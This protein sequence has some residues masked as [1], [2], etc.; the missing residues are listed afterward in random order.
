MDRNQIDTIHELAFVNTNM[1]AL[2]MSSN[3]LK[4]SSMDDTPFAHLIELRSLNVR[5]NSLDAFLTVWNTNCLHLERLDLSHNAIGVLNLGIVFD[6]WKRP[7]V[8][9]LSH[10]QL[11]TIITAYDIAS[12]PNSTWILN[13]NPLRC[14]C[15]VQPLVE[16]IRRPNEKIGLVVD[17][18]RC[19]APERLAGQSPITVDLAQLTCPLDSPGGAAKLCPAGCQCDVRVSDRTAIFNCT[20]A[21]LT[22]VP[23]LPAKDKLAGIRSYHLHIEHNR[24]GRLPARNTTGY[25]DVNYLFAGNNSIGSVAADELPDAMDLL[26]LT[27]N[28][29]WWLGGDALAHLGRMERLQNISLHANPWLCNCA[30]VEL[31]R[32]VR[33]NAHRIRASGRIMCANAP[34]TRLLDASDLCFW[35][36]LAV[37]VGGAAIAAVIV[38][39]AGLVLFHAYKLDALIWW[40]E[41][42]ARMC[43][44]LARRGR[45]D[46]K[47]FD[48]FVA[49]A[50]K[51][52]DFV[53]DNLVKEL[54]GGRPALKLRS[55]DRD[56]LAGECMQEKVSFYFGFRFFFRF[57]FSVF[58]ISANNLPA[59][60]RTFFRSQVTEFVEKSRKTIVVLTPNLVDSITKRR[61]AEHA[62][63]ETIVDSWTL[64]AF[65]FAHERGLQD[66]SSRIIIVICGNI[67]PIDDL[68]AELKAYL[69]THIYLRWDESRF[70]KKL[71]YAITHAN[72]PQKVRRDYV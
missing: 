48:A 14:D 52:A 29:I 27:A 11:S 44:S 65:L 59:V 64:R 15:L 22:A 72:Y 18:L 17:D 40:D 58:L 54:E 23:P 2:D 71:R 24:I 36:E 3:R 7:V 70:F 60:L 35:N 61:E 51:D 41:S 45:P 12:Q 1:R 26:D 62:T 6:Y 21:N 57:L 30:A 69:D 53:H 16:S 39:L 13:D 42:R 4:F 38:L 55:L 10:N 50:S 33:A 68:A 46:G 67:G 9:D 56:M 5:N 34:D 49:H 28:D 63:A 37:A 43:P 31:Q 20:A 66:R 47:E 8:I 19:A 25:R 32:F